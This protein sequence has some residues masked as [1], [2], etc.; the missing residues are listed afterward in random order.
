MEESHNR[1]PKEKVNK[2]KDV[3]SIKDRI[4]K[5]KKALNESGEEIPAELENLISEL[6]VLEAI[7]QE[8][9]VSLETLVEN[10]VEME[11]V[12]LDKPVL[13]VVQQLPEEL[14][15]QVS[16]LLSEVKMMDN[17]TPDVEPLK[18]S[19][20]VEPFQVKLE[21]VIE[22]IDQTIDAIQS[23]GSE[24]V[25][26]DLVK[27]LNHIKEVLGEAVYKDSEQNEE[28]SVKLKGL[29]KAFNMVESM[30]VKEDKPALN[31]LQELMNQQKVPVEVKVESRPATDANNLD[32]SSHKETTPGMVEVKTTIDADVK[33]EDAEV[34]VEVKGEVA[35]KTP[36]KANVETDTPTANVQKSETTLVVEQTVDQLVEVKET[37]EV[38]KIQT[39]QVAKV[40]QNIL[41][42]V[43]D[44]AKM[45]FNLEDE[46]SE[47]LI[48]LKP[49]SM[50]NVELK[51]SIEKGV[52]L[53]EFSVESQ[54]VKE[55]LESNLA[56]LRN[57]L[58]DKGFSIHD[59]NVSVNQEQA[60]QEQQHPRQRFVRQ[61]N[62]I[63]LQTAEHLFERA[64]LESYNTQSTIDFLG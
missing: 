46:T 36:T 27:V 62:R 7:P 26:E 9:M 28:T 38:S 57:A 33:L 40:H 3:E 13:E 12:E 25:D 8:L 44:A 47:M 49:N 30:G 2:D 22:S 20:E 52:L 6:E 42:Q 18:E 24:E 37:I 21:S 17:Q 15:T 32:F 35:D 4:K 48:K 19:E 5:L 31:K 43:V 34:K 53:A 64:S 10:F 41:N 56:D 45:S 51:V 39:T 63:E 16:E 11:N 60:N 58:S 59:L 23:E 50:G 55:A 61:Q 1:T 54:I 29:E 14:K